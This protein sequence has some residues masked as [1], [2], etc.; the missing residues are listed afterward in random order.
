M[1]VVTGDIWIR[2]TIVL[3]TICYASA[4]WLRFRRPTAWRWGRLAWTAGAVLLIVHVAA[5]F[6]FRHGWSHRRALESTAAQTAAVTGLDWG[7]GLFV[8]YAFIALWAADVLSWWRHPAA[9]AARGRK[10]RSALAAAFLFMFFNGAVLFAH[11]AMRWFGAA[12]VAAAA[13]AW[14][15]RSAE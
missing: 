12:C 6:H 8:N 10:R 4:E 14:Y 5:A 1:R 7:G 2:V 3:A 11:G 15:F 13:A 9:Y